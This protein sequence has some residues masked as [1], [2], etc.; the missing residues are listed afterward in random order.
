MWV[1]LNNIYLGLCSWKTFSFF[2][3]QINEILMHASIGE[4]GQIITLLACL[5]ITRVVF[6]SDF[7]TDWCKQTLV[8]VGQK[9]FVTFYTMKFAFVDLNS[10]SH[11][12]C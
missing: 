8:I 7:Y 9:C 11:V 6:T 3:Y 1:C 12:L 5:I 10:N 4:G 2:G